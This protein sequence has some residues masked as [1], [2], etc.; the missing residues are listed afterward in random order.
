MTV[1]IAGAGI[2][3]LTL[4]LTLEQLGVPFR[5]VEAARSLR[6]LGVGINL[7]PN[8]VRELDDLGLLRGLDRIGIPTEEWAL[9]TPTG[10]EV[11]AEP[12]GLAAGYRWPQYSVHRGQL[13]MLLY[14]ALRQRAGDDVVLPGHRIVDVDAGP[15]DATIV[16]E[17]RLDGAT[18]RID[19]SVVLGADGLHSAIR[20]WMWPDEGPPVW[21]GGVL[22]RATS[23]GPPVRTGASFVLLGTMDQRFVHYPIARPDPATGT[24]LQNWIA[25]LSFDPGAGWRR[26]DWNQR[27][28]IDEFAPAFADW[29]VGWLDVP[30]LIASA[31][32]VFEYPMVDRDPAAAWVRG[33]VGL[34]GDAA[35]VMYPVGSNGAS[36]AI[37]D[38]RVLGARFVEH[39]V[40]PSALEAYQDTLLEPISALVLRNRGAGPIAILGEVER[41]ARGDLATVTH[42]GDVIPPSEVEAFMADYRA[43]AGVAVEA[44]NTA[45]PTIEPG[46]RVA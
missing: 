45:P 11:Y 26:S 10:V 28:E 14:D 46:A 3:G 20:A 6:P 43:A 24:Q 42:V 39:G 18:V 33:R 31:P 27:V 21:G 23:F 17:R 41:R 35:H 7:Q 44:L 8:A 40:G 16:C 22:W 19:G 29:D 12:R 32:E 13:Q 34:I 25:E 15:D 2:A 4:G 38:A 9:A 1:V 30:G 37:V 36:Q 5:I